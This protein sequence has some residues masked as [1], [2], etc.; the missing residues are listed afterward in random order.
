MGVRTAT[1]QR[2]LAV[3]GVASALAASACCILPLG[4]A[5]AGV[6]GASAGFFAAMAPYQPFFLGVAIVCLGVGFRLAYWPSGEACHEA[7]ACAR[8]AGPLI[9]GLLWVKGMLWLGTTI[10]MLAVGVDVGGRVLF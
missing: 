9:G 10:V 4:L 2:L 5:A 6:A 1:E 3:G 8:T 7:G